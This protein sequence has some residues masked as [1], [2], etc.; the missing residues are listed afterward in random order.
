MSPAEALVLIRQLID[1]MSKTDAEVVDVIENILKAVE[2][3][4]TC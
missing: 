4:T 1:D 2:R 3:T